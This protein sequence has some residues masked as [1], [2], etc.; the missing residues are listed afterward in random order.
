MNMFAEVSQV[1]SSRVESYW[2]L[3][4]TDNLSR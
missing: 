3:F 1:E 4:V 2:Y